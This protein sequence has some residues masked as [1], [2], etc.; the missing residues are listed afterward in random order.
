MTIETEIAPP[1]LP[2][3]AALFSATAALAACGGGGGDSGPA[4]TP[5]P[6]PAPTP[7]PVALTDGDAARFHGQAAFGVGSATSSADN[8]AVKTRG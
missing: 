1:A 3:L 7:A 2:G 6:A 8:A 5:T 4:P